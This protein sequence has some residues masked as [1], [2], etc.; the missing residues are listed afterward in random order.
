[1]GVRGKDFSP[2]GSLESSSLCL[3]DAAVPY[4]DAWSYNDLH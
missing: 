4:G 2:S 3:C 1:M